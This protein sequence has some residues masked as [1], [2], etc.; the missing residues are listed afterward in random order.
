MLIC[1]YPPL[2][3]YSHSTGLFGLILLNR[4]RAHLVY[5]I[6][7]FLYETGAPSNNQ[8]AGLG[9]KR[10]DLHGLEMIRSMTPAHDRSIVR[11]C[12]PRGHTCPLT[13]HG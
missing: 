9:S 2:C 10:E 4:V 6:W 13:H 1:S 3:N 8:R 11:S 7:S 12:T 5:C